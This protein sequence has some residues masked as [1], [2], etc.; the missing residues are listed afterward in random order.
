VPNKGEGEAVFDCQV[1]QCSDF[2]EDEVIPTHALTGQYFPE[3]IAPDMKM[4]GW[5]SGVCTGEGLESF[6]RASDLADSTG[7]RVPYGG[8]LI[9]M[10]WRSAGVKGIDV[11]QWEFLTCAPNADS[12]AS[13]TN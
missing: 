5:P 12:L 6:K 4:L 11:R 1:V 7:E 8:P 3:V 10:R 9:C 2:L 13:V